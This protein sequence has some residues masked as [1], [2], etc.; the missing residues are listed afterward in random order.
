MNLFEFGLLGAAGF[1]A[2]GINAVAGGG[3]LISFPALL[4]AGYPSVTANVTN[5]VA[6]W[7]GTIGG[8]WAYRRELEGQRQRMVLL[9][10][11]S[12]IGAL[13][14][15]GL[16]LAIPASYFDRVVP[17]LI[18][19][20]CALLA[21]QTRIARWVHQRQQGKAGDG[22]AGPLIAGQ[23]LASVYGGYFTAGLGILVLAILGIFIRD[24]L[25]R[26]NALKG[27][28]SVVINGVSVIYFGL[29]GPV[30]WTVVALMAVTS[31]LGGYFGVRAARR[32]SPDKLRAL[33]FVYGVIVALWLLI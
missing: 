7:P 30:V 28:L 15:S 22:R 19:F 16:L 31:T 17:F 5:T 27:L 25:Q 26:L 14:G 12:A 10:I 21:G 8:S 24:H 3:S 2:G 11:I 13:I 32:L 9:G 29:F 6:V 4:A 33:V 23:F 18:L 20:A 1:I